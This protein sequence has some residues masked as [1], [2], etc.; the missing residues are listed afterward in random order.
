M[1]L[2]QT[3]QNPGA[4]NLPIGI[5][6]AT[7]GL[8]LNTPDTLYTT[9]TSVLT[10]SRDSLERGVGMGTSKLPEMGPIQEKSNFDD[11]TLFFMFYSAPRDR[12]QLVA[13]A[14]LYRRGWRF[15]KKDQCWY[16]PTGWEAEGEKVNHNEFDC[17]DPLSWKVVVQ[18]NPVLDH[19]LFEIQA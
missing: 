14:M 10:D 16:R 7:L 17:F 8:D 12:M 11:S 9:Y 19:G 18:V 15:Y 3:I 1:G 2:L 6:V 5:D 13:S 4:G